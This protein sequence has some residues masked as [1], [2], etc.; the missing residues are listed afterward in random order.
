[1]D[2]GELM[3]LI[4]DGIQKSD[5]FQNVKDG[6]D[7]NLEG[8][9]EN[10]LANHGT[11]EHQYQQYGEVRADILVVKTTVATAEKGLADLSTYV[12]AQIGP[13]GSLT[14]AVNQ[15]MTAEVNSDGTAKASYTLNMGIVRNGVKY[16]T[17]FGMSIEPSGNSYKST[18]VF[19]ADQFGIYSGSDPGNYTA[20]FFVYNG[21]VF[22]RDALIQ[23]GSISNAKI[24]N[25]IQSNNFVAGSTGWRIDKNGNA[26]LHGK[27][28]ADSGQFA[29]NGENNTVV[30]NGNGVTVNLPGGGRV[31]VGRW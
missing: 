8:I 19:A 18:V 17:G 1:M 14:S 12:Q 15:K 11:V 28:Y 26:E 24:G 4:D 23:D 5:A 29:F 3:D 16:N 30:I 20:A 31:V 7:T 9:M 2:T 22:I 6:V 13:E 27:L 10:S 25:Y 21:Q